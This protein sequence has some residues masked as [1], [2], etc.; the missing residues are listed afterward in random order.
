L[1]MNPYGMNFMNNSEQIKADYKL[2]SMK[3]MMKY[4]EEEENMLSEL[5]QLDNSIMD[6]NSSFTSI[7]LAFGLISFSVF[8]SYKIMNNSLNFKSELFNGKLFG[9]GICYK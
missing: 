2:E 6:I 1:M 7:T 9:E 4:T 3:E 8:V 5:K